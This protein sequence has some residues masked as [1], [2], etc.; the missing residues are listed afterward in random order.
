MRNGKNNKYFI[1]IAAAY[2]K[3]TNQINSFAHIIYRS[4]VLTANVVIKPLCLIRISTKAKDVNISP[5]KVHYLTCIPFYHLPRIYK[6][7]S[8]LK[9]SPARLLTDED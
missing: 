5:F 8:E 2:Q 3:T 1:K 4:V 6:N 9:T 7:I